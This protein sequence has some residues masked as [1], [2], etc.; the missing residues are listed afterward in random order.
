MQHTMSRS[1]MP[2]KRPATT[3]RTVARKAPREDQPAT[4]DPLDLVPTRAELLALRAWQRVTERL[5]RPATLR[6]TSAEL[7]MSPNGA[8]NAL[9]AC[10]RK[11]LRVLREVVRY[12]PVKLSPSGRRWL[13]QIEPRE[14]ERAE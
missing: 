13:K 12:M 1:N 5:G 3:A 2:P 4:V 11:G 14:S 8:Q 9:D 6:E 10:D 7:G